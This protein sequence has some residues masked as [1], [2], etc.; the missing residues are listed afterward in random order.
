M[1]RIENSEIICNFLAVFQV[2]ILLLLLLL[3]F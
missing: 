3:L 2:V 1:S